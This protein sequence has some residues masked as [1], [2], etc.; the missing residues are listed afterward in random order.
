MQGIQHFKEK[1]LHL[2]IV[3]HHYSLLKSFLRNEVAKQ[4]LADHSVGICQSY[5]YVM[6]MHSCRKNDKLIGTLLIRVKG[7]CLFVFN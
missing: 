4:P 7:F 1:H 6:K 5:D 2:V 3:G